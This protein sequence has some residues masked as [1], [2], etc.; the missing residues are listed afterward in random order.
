MEPV[1]IRVT[2]DDRDK[3]QPLEREKL[4][5][6]SAICAHRDGSGHAVDAKG[7][8]LRPQA[9][10]VSAHSASIRWRTQVS[11]RESHAPSI[12]RSGRGRERFERRIVAHLPEFSA[13]A[14]LL[15]RTDMLGTSP[16]LFMMEGLEIDADRPH[17]TLPAAGHHITLLFKGAA[18]SGPR[19]PLA[20]VRRHRRTR[21]I[22]VPVASRADST[23][24]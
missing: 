10:A 16:H 20:A 6:H 13:V 3:L 8:M 19:L 1:A 7:H 15:A 17:T 12:G 9:L 21:A 5:G 22:G 4:V 2:D 14:P 24:R 11:P 18:I 23:A